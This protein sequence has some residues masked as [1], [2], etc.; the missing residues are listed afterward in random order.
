MK[1]VLFIIALSAVILSCD[2][3]EEKTTEETTNPAG[4]QNV[5]GNI[6][7]TTNA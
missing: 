7:D 1:K 4:I 5:N 6:P 2:S 3:K